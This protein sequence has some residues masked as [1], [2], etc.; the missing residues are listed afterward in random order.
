MDETQRLRFFRI[1]VLGKSNCGKTCLV[2]SWVSRS[3][4]E[5][6]IRTEKAGVYLKQVEMADESEGVDDVMRPVL[7]EVEDTPG[8]DRGAEE[9]E[10]DKRDGPPKVLK[11]AR[12]QLTRDKPQLWK[13]FDKFNESKPVDGK[14]HFKPGMD[15]MLGQEYIVRTVGRG[16]IIHLP[17]PDGSEGGIWSF[18][19][20]SCI[21]KVSLQ[22]PIDKFLGLDEKQLPEFTSSK[23]K[24]QYLSAL[25]R[26]LSAYERPPPT[27]SVDKTLTKSR[28]GYFICFDLS[29]EDGASLKEAMSVVQLLKKTLAFGRVHPHIW[30]V[31][32][33]SDKTLN[34]KVVDKNH[35]SAAVFAEQEEVVFRTTSAREH[36]NVNNV[37]AEM[38]QAINARENLWTLQGNIDED[39]E[40]KTGGA[41]FSQ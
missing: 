14:I 39:E 26:P 13:L 2:N 20:G 34:N 8:S 24:K 1:T 23:Q 27:P 33:K 7:V 15:A 22:L 25:Q 35:R 18:P 40:E 10:S 38:I 16:G 31:G 19:P 17:S 4:P 30:L 12:V 9:D 3:F 37:F 36:K 11:G 41:C 21:I 5:R 6:Y 28:M 32:C 29:D